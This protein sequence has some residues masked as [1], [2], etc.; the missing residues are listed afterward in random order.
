MPR[1]LLDVSRIHAL[2]W[3]HRMSL[4]DGLERTYRWFVGQ[5][6]SEMVPRGM[7]EPVAQNGT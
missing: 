4:R 7:P 5:L 1:K 2:G 6:E 3:R